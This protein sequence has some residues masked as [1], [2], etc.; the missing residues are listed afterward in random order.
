MIEF[1]QLALQE[2]RQAQAWYRA[3]S[4]QAAERFYLKVQ[5]AIERLQID[6][7]SHAMIGRDC[8]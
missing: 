1:H 2:L 7:S 8:H 4:Q 3:R 5:R 6:P